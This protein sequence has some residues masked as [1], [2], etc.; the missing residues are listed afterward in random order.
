M[1]I[2][3]SHGFNQTPFLDA[4][5]SLAPTL[6]VR[7]LTY[8]LFSLVPPLKVLSTKNLILARLGVSLGRS[9]ST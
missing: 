3:Y 9:T 8:M 2:G 1:F 4:Q 7:W 5:A 6:G